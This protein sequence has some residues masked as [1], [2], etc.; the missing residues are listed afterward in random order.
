MPSENQEFFADYA[1]GS[2]D[3]RETRGTLADPEADYPLE[4]R[5]CITGEDVKHSY[6]RYPDEVQATVMVMSHETML[7]YSRRGQSLSVE[8]ARVLEL[9]RKLEKRRR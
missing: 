8:F 9:R 4:K 2:P 1:T 6:C 5:C 7:R 3:D